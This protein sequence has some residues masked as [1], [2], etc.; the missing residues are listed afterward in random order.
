LESK[1]RKR[2]DVKER[3]HSVGRSVDQEDR[4]GARKEG[5]GSKNVDRRP[6]SRQISDDDD[7]EHDEGD[8]YVDLTLSDDE[9][10]SITDNEDTAFSSFQVVSN[11]T[12]RTVGKKTVKSFSSSRSTASQLSRKPSEFY[13]ANPSISTYAASRKPLR[14]SAASGKPTSFSSST[15]KQTPFRLTRSISSGTVY[16]YFQQ[17]LDHISS[18]P[19]EPTFT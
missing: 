1:K 17:N 5:C 12:D 7:R 8:V 16:K 10:G 15:A 18:S 19:D 9:I 14:A 2:D 3:Q 13:T 4:N 6:S 11:R